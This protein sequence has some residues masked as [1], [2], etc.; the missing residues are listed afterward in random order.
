MDAA[1]EADWSTEYLDA[2]L[3]VAVVDGVGGAVD[4]VSRWGTHH[5]DCIVT[6]DAEAAERFMT[7]VDSALVLHNAPTQ[8]A[9][10]GACDLGTRSGR[11]VKRR[12][13][14]AHVRP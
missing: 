10:G 7:E 3:S 9:D 12:E 5:T 13:G 11:S 14:K 6:E 2:M 4:H 8:I 1:T